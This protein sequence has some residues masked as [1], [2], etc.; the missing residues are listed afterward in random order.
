MSKPP[1]E[2][3]KLK[4][5]RY[6]IEN[7]DVRPVTNTDKDKWCYR[8]A[9]RNNQPVS[10]ED[11]GYVMTIPSVSQGRN[12]ILKGI[13]GYAILRSKKFQGQLF[14]QIVLTGNPKQYGISSQNREGKSKHNK[15]KKQNLLS[16]RNLQ[17]GNFK[18]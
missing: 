11:W 16:I 3:R 12:I 18:N 8:P 6:L 13:E 9:K 17:K 7:F 2:P 10:P 4:P 15:R 14:L 5:I 1:K